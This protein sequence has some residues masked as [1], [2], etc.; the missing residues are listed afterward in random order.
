MRA[1]SRDERPVRMVPTVILV[2]LLCACVAQIGVGALYPRP[3]R[4]AESL[5]RPAD[6]TLIRI[7]SLDERAVAARVMMIHLQSFDLSSSNSAPYRALDYGL[8]A[9]WL[10]RALELDPK[11][12]YP[13]FMAT[14]IY[15]EISDA[16]K[17]R[18]MLAFVHAKFLEDRLG[19]WQWL[20]HGALIA[21]HKLKDLPLAR[22]YAAELTRL[23]KS[24]PGLPVWVQEMESFVLEDMGE[25]EAARIM[26]G[27]LLEGGHITDEDEIRFLRLR[28]RQLESALSSERPL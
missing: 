12:Q 3:S 17:V 18:M 9:L 8:L 11:S 22:V 26:L 16:S 20:A 14:H 28:M 15:M 24:V 21:K 27:G 23:S 5:G 10:Q 2:A 1:S 6:T 25:L 19:R 7:A 4:G 13:L